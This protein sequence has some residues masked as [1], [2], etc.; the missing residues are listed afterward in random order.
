VTLIFD[1]NCD[2]IHRKEIF[3]IWKKYR[4]LNKTQLTISIMNKWVKQTFFVIW[5][6]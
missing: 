4:C 3:H 5:W 6:T 1:W 2:R